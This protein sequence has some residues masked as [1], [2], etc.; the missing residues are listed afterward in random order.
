MAD[1]RQKLGGAQEKSEFFRTL[2]KIG[3]IEALN[4]I[5]SNIG[6]GLRSLETISNQLRTGGAV[7]EIWRNVEASVETGADS[8]LSVVGIDPTA[9][10]D[11][12]NRF[13]PGVLNRAVGQAE[14]IYER[15][16]QGNFEIRDVPEAIQDFGNLTQLLGGV[17]T[18]K[19]GESE[20][21]RAINLICDPSPF[22]VDLINLA[23][24]HKFMFIVEFVFSS[25][26]KDDFRDL[27]FAF[28]IKRTTRP[29]IQFEYED[30][31][32]Y[33]FR[34]KVLKKSEYQPMTMTF[35]DDMLDNALR[36]YNRYLQIISP[37]SRGDGQQSLFEESGMTFDQDNG[38]NTAS[39]NAVGDTTKTI[40]HHINLYHII[41]AGRQV[42]FY[43]FDSPRLQNIQLDDLDMTE[44]G[45]GTEVTVEFNYDRVSILPGQDIREF[46]DQIRDGSSGGE[47]NI[48]LTNIRGSEQPST[49]NS[50]DGVP[51]TANYIQEPKT[52]AASASVPTT[53][54]VIRT[55]AHEAQL[56]AVNE[57]NTNL[58]QEMKAE[59]A[60]SLG[61]SV[62]TNPAP[63][64]P[65]NDPLCRDLY[66][67]ASAAQ[68]DQ[69]ALF[70]HFSDQ[71]DFISNLRSRGAAQSDIDRELLEL[72][73][74]KVER[75]A[76]GPIAREAGRKAS[77]CQAAGGTNFFNG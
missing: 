70:E 54:D 11:L 37:I 63:A 55:R 64:V 40:I 22:A 9:A 5:D 35:Y 18:P 16:R 44:T 8:V 30:I 42:D 7:A 74:I 33:N 68:N 4:N 75:D 46:Q 10:K 6:Q 15:V 65:K 21:L 25:N 14:Q 53:D 28:V 23:P 57:S 2:G 12:G 47:Y 48:S 69:N 73:R 32:Y 72:D 58:E 71:A 36:F 1:P 76:Q 34:T 31:N 59:L 60:E 29:Q 51:R 67:Q 50:I 43:K 20:E 49:T 38:M 56:D 3:D 27:N 61:A 66:N 77:E 62:N 13:N 19:I 24:K 26:Y 45:T 39:I 41:H 52:T 17:F